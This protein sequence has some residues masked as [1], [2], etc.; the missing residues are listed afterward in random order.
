MKAILNSLVMGACCAVVGLLASIAIVLLAT[1]TG[2]EVMLFTAPMAA[3]LTGSVFWWIFRAR[4]GSYGVR[5]GAVT[6]AAAGIVA[7]FVCWYLTILGASVCFITTG[8]CT[9]SLGGAPVDPLFGLIGATILSVVS[10]LFAG[11]FTVPVGALIGGALAHLQG[12]A[13][14]G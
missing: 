1:G 7:H 9:D 10:L 8:G 3:F 6:G 11:W 13:S 12:R 4:Q 5:G 14:R 2:Y